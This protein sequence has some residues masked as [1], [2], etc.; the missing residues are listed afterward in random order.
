MNQPNPESLSGTRRSL[1]EHDARAVVDAPAKLNLSLS[2]LGRRADGYH[3]LDSLVAPIHIADRVTVWVSA[4]ADPFVSFRVVPDGAAPAGAENLCVRAAVLYLDRT[5]TT[6]RI[7]IELEKHLPIGAGMG[8]GSSDAAAI[9]RSLN[10]LADRPVPRAELSGWALEL[11]AD[12]PFFL[13]GGPARMQGIGEILQPAIVP[14]SI[15]PGLVVAFHGTPLETR[16]VYAKYDDSLT[17]E[18]SASRVRG[19]IVRN[20][21]SPD[22]LANDLEAAACQLLPSLRALKQQLRGLGARDVA[23]TGSGSAIFGLWNCAEEA[24]NAAR[25]LE[26]MGIWAR[27]TSI[28]DTLPDVAVRDAD[29]D[30]RSPSW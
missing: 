19:F 12:V 5:R 1:R 6:A 26:A 20:G 2:I 21:P 8:G 14:S 15:G 3:E 18:Q 30:G 24:E 29:D 17:S 22:F 27:A 13:L 11:G 7:R 9:L 10:T 25:S 28:L 4:N 23:M 16:H